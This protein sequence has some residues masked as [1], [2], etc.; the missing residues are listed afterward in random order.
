M[1]KIIVSVLIAALVLIS[2]GCG[3]SSSA[4]AVK[5]SDD[6]VVDEVLA[7]KDVSK[8]DALNG[9]V[10]GF[11]LFKKCFDGSGNTLI[12]PLSVMSALA[13]TASGAEGLTKEQMEKVLGPEGWGD[14]PGLDMYIFN[15][16]NT[17]PPMTARL[18]FR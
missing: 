2:F 4:S 16:L 11:E 14:G 6:P 8:S 10:F 12:S 15:Y 9:T 18:S 5:I 17:L 13:M 1:K 3:G 7:P